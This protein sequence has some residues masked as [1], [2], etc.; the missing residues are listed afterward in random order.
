M[1]RAFTHLLHYV[2]LVQNIQ[3]T[4]DLHIESYCIL[5]AHQ[6]KECEF[7]KMQLYVQTLATGSLQDYQK[8]FK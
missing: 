3:S 4:N 5:K 2:F 1:I 6:G 8:T 7:Q